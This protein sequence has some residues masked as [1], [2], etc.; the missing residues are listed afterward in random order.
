M[1]QAEGAI[2]RSECWHERI[3]SRCI[4]SKALSW[5]RRDLSILTIL[6][7]DFAKMRV[8]F[9]RYSNLPLSYS[10]SLFLSFILFS[11]FL[12][13]PSPVSRVLQLSS[14][15]E[16]TPGQASFRS[17]SPLLSLFYLR[18]LGQE[19]KRAG[20]TSASKRNK[21]LYLYPQPILYVRKSIL[22]ETAFAANLHSA[23]IF[24]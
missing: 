22:F 4:S 7:H 23:A 24:K 18:L 16:S 17:Q 12:T 9:L 6:V 2:D 3:S 5:E 13:H 8:S 20:K 1:I 10:L 11:V 15:V 21:K 14:T 19:I